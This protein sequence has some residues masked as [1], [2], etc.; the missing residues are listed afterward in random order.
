MAV[1]LKHTTQ[2]TGTD[3]GTGEIRKTQWNEEHTLS[4]ATGKLLGRTTAGTG[5]AEE[6]TPGSGLTFSSGS[7]SVDFTGYLT[8]TSAAATYAPLASPSLT[9]TP[10]A[11]TAAVDTNTTQLA[12]TA[13]V[14]GQGYL[15]SAT[16]S[17]TYAPISTTV[18]LTGT[19]TLSGK[20]ITSV[21][22]F[23][24]RVAV[25]ASAIDLATGNYFSK[26]I[27]GTTTFTVSN[28]PAS[29]TA[30]SFILDL[31][32][33]GSATVNWWSGVKWASGAAP[34]LTASGR[35]V[36]GF[37]TYDG[38]TTWTGLVLGKDVK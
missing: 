18:T 14:I 35:D 9:G 37:F 2:A 17:S 5:A 10:T 6:I 12:T 8:T 20:T 25:A 36:L 34:T 26:T 23:E 7:I 3:A 29:G 38:G 15:K 13:Y 11:P 32:N 21:A 24:T 31:T 27:S 30:A 19:Q 16:A 33:G 28:T 4:L 1:S 22:S